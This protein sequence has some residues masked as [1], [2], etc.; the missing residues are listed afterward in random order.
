M[1]R[2]SDVITCPFCL[3][4]FTQK[5]SSELGQKR[6]AMKLLVEGGMPLREIGRLLNEHPQTVKYWAEKKVYKKD[7]FS[8]KE[9]QDEQD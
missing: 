4:P 2:P 7:S 9:V 1:S 8:L 3:K 6:L 5:E